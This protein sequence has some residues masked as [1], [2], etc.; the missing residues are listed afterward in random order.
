MKNI[1]ALIE[2]NHPLEEIMD[3]MA[4]EKLEEASGLSVGTNV[5]IMK[6]KF[7][8]K[9]GAIEEIKKIY[10]TLEDLGSAAGHAMRR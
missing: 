1:K 9:R 4:P 5:G 2:S 8:G 6:G 7:K 10:E 3:L